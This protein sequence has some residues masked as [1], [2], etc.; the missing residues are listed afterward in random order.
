MR[1]VYF[2]DLRLRSFAE[3]NVFN[4][5]YLGVFNM[6]MT[7]MSAMN[8]VELVVGFFSLAYEKV[9]ANISSAYMQLSLGLMA[10][11]SWSFNNIAEAACSTGASTEIGK[12]L[13]KICTIQE[14]ISGLEA[15]AGGIY[16]VILGIII[17]GVIAGIIISILKG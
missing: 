6:A 7:R 8:P 14:S 9:K 3:L 11:V 4:I 16:T 13:E 15:T 10:L 1:L 12:M 5:F 17:V 2:S